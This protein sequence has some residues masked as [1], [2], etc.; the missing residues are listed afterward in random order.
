MPNPFAMALAILGAGNVGLALGRAFTR[1]GEAVIFGVQDPAKAAA[2]VAALGPGATVT[3]VSEA[4]EAAELLILAVPC[5][6]V[7]S[8]AASRAD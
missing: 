6:A 8:I 3:T 7:A 2:A 5:G 1:M 4:I